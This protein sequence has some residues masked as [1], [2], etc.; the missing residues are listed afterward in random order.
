M[1]RICDFHSYISMAASSRF[2][3]GVHVLVF[4]AHQ[5]KR[6]ASS[7]E[8]AASVN[9]HP[10]VLRR[11]LS[12]FVHAR[13]VQPRKGAAGGFY[14]VRKPSD[15]SLLSIYQIVEGHPVLGQASNAPNRAC[16]VGAGI[17]RVVKQICGEAQKALEKQLSRSSLADAHRETCHAGT[18]IL[19]KRTS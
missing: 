2:A 10:V 8:I 13:L 11:L 17:G 3:V 7:A 1:E 6:P 4:L 18:R 14:L 9:T 16:P 15:I 12:S 5:G 19:S